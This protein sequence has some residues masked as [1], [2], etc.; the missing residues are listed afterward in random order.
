MLSAQT[1]ATISP[2]RNTI[3]A[4][5]V[6]KK[7]DNIWSKNNNIVNSHFLTIAIP[8]SAACCSSKLSVA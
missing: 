8:E 3:T 5:C 7:K 6:H 1:V 4:A 2:F